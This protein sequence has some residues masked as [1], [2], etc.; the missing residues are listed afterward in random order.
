MIQKI[1]TDQKTRWIQKF[2]KIQRNQRD[3]K[4]R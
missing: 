3:L 2:Q 1:R 4:F